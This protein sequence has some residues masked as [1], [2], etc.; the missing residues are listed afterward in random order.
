M[1]KSKKDAGCLPLFLKGPL[2]EHS[3]RIFSATVADPP[4]S[5]LLRAGVT[6]VY[7]IPSLLC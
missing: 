5:A 7:Q 4:V 2:T 6:E 3:D 1:W